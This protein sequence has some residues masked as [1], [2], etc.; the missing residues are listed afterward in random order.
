M[1]LLFMMPAIF[2]ELHNEEWSIYAKHAL[3][4]MKKDNVPEE[5][6][7][8]SDIEKLKDYLKAE[9]K[10]CLQNE[11]MDRKMDTFEP[12]NVGKDHHL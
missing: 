11:S 3:D 8:P 10:D 7:L 4:S 6:P 9:I 12:S 1:I 2:L 5:L